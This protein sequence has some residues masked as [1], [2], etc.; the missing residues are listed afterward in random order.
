MCAYNC[1]DVKNEMITHRLTGM[2]PV[3]DFIGDV[4][5]G[6]SC[7]KKNATQLNLR[8]VVESRRRDI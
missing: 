8:F 2:S 6:S 3:G 7:E 5:R 4:E 1:S